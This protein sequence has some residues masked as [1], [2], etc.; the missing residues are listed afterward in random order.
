MSLKRNKKFNKFP[1]EESE[2]LDLVETINDVDKIKNKRVSILI[3]LLL[4]VGISF[5]FWF[6][7]QYKSFSFSQIKIP[8]LSISKFSPDIPQD[9]S[10]FVNTIGSTTFSYLSNY[11]TSTNYTNISIP[12]NPSYAKRYLPDGVSVQEKINDTSFFLEILS[13]ISTPKISFQIYTKIPGKIDSSSPE[14][15]TFSKLVATFYWHLLK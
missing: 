3:F 4:T 13:Q 8:S 15:D 12:H 10:L 7:R 11:D 14:I 1:S 5:G 6:Y 9:W 2:Q